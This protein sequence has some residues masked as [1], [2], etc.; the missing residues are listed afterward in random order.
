MRI[1]KFWVGL[2]RPT[3]LRIRPVLKLSISGCKLEQEVSFKVKFKPKLSWV[4]KVYLGN[5]L[6]ELLGTV[7]KATSAFDFEVISSE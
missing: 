4:D 2:R 3:S 6:I 5:M 1:K 7:S